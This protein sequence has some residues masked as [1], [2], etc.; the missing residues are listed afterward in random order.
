MR[1]LRRQLEASKTDA[2]A[3][4]DAGKKALDA[5]NKDLKAQ[6]STLNPPPSN[7]KYLDLQPSTPDHEP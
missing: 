2:A 1:F 3:A 7:S 5:A 4:K 6:P